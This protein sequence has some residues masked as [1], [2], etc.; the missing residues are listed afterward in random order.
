MNKIVP[1]VMNSSMITVHVHTY[2]PFIWHTWWAWRKWAPHSF[3][4][5]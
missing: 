1:Y 2:G 4:V 5:L 3:G